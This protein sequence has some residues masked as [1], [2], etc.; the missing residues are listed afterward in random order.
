LVRHYY[1]GWQPKNVTTAAD[2]DQMAERTPSTR[3]LRRVLGEAP[4]FGLSTRE[5]RD[6]ERARG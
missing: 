1:D 4:A 2:R 5:E 6:H 3:A